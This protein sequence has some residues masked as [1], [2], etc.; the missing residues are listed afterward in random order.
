M[1]HLEIIIIGIILIFIVTYRLSTGSGV[2]KFINEQTTKLYDKYAP[3]SYKEM[4]KK[5]KSLGLDYTP[6]QYF[7]QVV[8]FAGIAGAIGYLYFYNLIV[9]IVY[10]VIAIIFI[11]YITYLRSKRQYSEFIFEQVQ[12]YVTNT[13]MEFATT[14]AFIKSLEGVVESGIL[15]DPVLSD[16]KTMIAL[17][18]E[19]GEVTDSI[20]YM[21]A[22]YPY[23]MVKNMHQLFLQVTKEGAKDTEETFDNMLTDIDALVEGV[24]RDRLDRSEFH[25][26]FLLFGVALYGIVI[27]IQLLL[28]VPSYIAMLDNIIIV[29]LLHALVIINT[30]FLL[31]GEK[32]YNENVGAE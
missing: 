31:K 17:S 2:Y 11:P 30:L 8:L 26:Q 29:V 3:Y 27:L 15:E 6:R 23:F 12:V 22:K 18:Y 19:K 24:Y 5:I 16:V 4:R 13:I 28:G 7:V 9:S 10:A 32:Y 25:K 21:N 1:V 20:A 14:Q